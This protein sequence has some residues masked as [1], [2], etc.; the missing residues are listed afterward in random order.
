MR[1][2]VRL[3]VVG[4]IIAHHDFWFWEDPTL[5]FGFMPVGLFYHTCLSIAAAV[6]WWLACTFA[7][8]FEEFG[9]DVD[10]QVGGS[11]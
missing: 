1:I 2:V 10:S 8:P 11:A 5:V 4:L 6:V 7:W 3:L 9:P